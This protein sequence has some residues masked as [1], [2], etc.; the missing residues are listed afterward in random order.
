MCE[1]ADVDVQE[2]GRLLDFGLVGVIT[3]VFDRFNGTVE[4]GV[5]DRLAVDVKGLVFFFIIVILIAR[6][7]A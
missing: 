4:E 5:V 2:D 1:G 3:W 6:D 7:V